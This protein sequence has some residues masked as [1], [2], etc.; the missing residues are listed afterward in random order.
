MGRSH[1]GKMLKLPSVTLLIFNPAHGANVSAKILSFVC[2]H[3]EFGDVV[4][5]ADSRPTIQFPGKHI[6][7]P[8]VDW[9]EGQRWQAY[10]LGKY[11]HT[12]FMLHIETDGFPFNFN[13]WED[14]F[15][16][17]DYIGAPWPS[18]CLRYGQHEVGNGGCSLQSK[19]FREV[20]WNNRH[21]YWKGCPSDVFFVTPA[22]MAEH[23]LAGV[24]IAPKDIAIRFSYE[25]PMPEY[26]EWNYA[27]S[28]GFHGK[29]PGCVPMIEKALNDK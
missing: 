16:N 24:K 25:N 23:N 3:I 1:V 22:I 5:L 13:L 2:K 27:K 14:E 10:E 7:V 15:L 12:P 18:H 4:H 9:E 21:L 11:F 29:F 26:P 6:D 19:K 17:Y 8:N 28:F 20:L